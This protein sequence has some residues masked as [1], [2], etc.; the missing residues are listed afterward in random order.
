MAIRATLRV[1]GIKEARLR[2]DLV[3]LRARRPEPA[4]RA[5][6]TLDDL[7][8]GER[9][10]FDS[11][12]GWRRN[13]PAWTRE[14]RRRGLD[15][16]VA[17]AT[18]RLERALTSPASARGLTFRAF[19]GTLYWGIPQGRSDLFYA[20]AIAKNRG[21]RRGIKTVV[22]DMETRRRIAVRL[23]RYIAEDTIS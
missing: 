6:E 5:T 15:P 8:A 22:I 2:T 9:R 10:R 14:K 7:T 20:Q 11:T 13:T 17:R 18:G 3:G 19:N 4:L 23:E 12:R 21:G 16:R 1:D